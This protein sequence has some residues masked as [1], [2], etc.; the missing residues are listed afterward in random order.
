MEEQATYKLDELDKPLF[1]SRSSEVFAWEGDEK[2][3]KL[4]KSGVD[5]NM[6]DNEEINTTDTYQKGVSAVECYG[7]TR[8]LCPDGTIRSGIILKKFPAKL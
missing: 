3:L 6:I 7:Q 2:L 8:V 1:T 4:F 5:Q